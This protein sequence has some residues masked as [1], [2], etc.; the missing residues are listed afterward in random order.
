ME[1]T[2]PNDRY[3][4][5]LFGAGVAV[6]TALGILALQELTGFVLIALALVPVA[7]FTAYK[8]KGVIA[9]G[10]VFFALL[11]F[12]QDSGTNIR[13]ALYY[14]YIAGVVAIMVPW[15]A[16]TGQWRLRHG[17]D[18]AYLVLLIFVGY[19]IVLGFFTGGFMKNRIDDITLMFPILTYFV[20]R[21]QMVDDKVVRNILIVLVVM[22]LFI[23]LRN[24]RNYQQILLEAVMDW[25]VQKARVAKN[26]I[27][28][29]AGAVGFFILQAY[30]T[31]WI[32]RLFYL[33]VFGFMFAGLI[34]TQ[35]RGYWLAFAVSV[36]VFMLFSDRSARVRA[37]ITSTL[38]GFVAITIAFT[39]YYS[40]TLLVLENLAYRLSL[41]GGS[42]MDPSLLE[43]V[44]ETQSVWDLVKLNP[45][46]GYGFGYVYQRYGV[47]SGYWTHTS[48]VH[49]G[50]LAV[51]FKMGLFG[52]LA[53]ITYLIMIARTGYRV[54]KAATSPFARITALI[55]L[56]QVIGMM[57]V[58]ITSPQ[59]LG[60]DSMLLLAVMGA[61]VASLADRHTQALV[62]PA[63]K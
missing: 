13:E 40:A 3:G 16:L 33:G 41:T 60:F 45:F 44:L 11:T 9:Y 53:A 4:W 32:P 20:L 55:I 14:A 56:C 47:I 52:M 17:V 57:L 43:R 31:K 18:K 34:L 30:Q 1:A 25:Q 35:S 61:M 22:M 28:L 42:Q 8:H 23:A 37:L 5:L 50:Y 26:E 36:G 24:I 19:G 21:D 39:V 2:Y 7:L 54:F 27:F 6:I 38:L 59:F 46:A 29:M 12:D 10:L 63:T 51:W 15:L 49:N 58:N 62:P 48:Y